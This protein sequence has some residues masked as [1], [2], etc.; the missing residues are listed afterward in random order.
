MLVRVLRVI[1]A[2][3]ALV[4]PTGVAVLDASPASASCPVPTGYPVLTGDLHIDGIP[5]SGARLVATG[6][7]FRAG[8]P[9]C[10][11]VASSPVEFAVATATKTGGFTSKITLPGLTLGQHILR[12]VGHARDGSTLILN[13]AFTNGYALPNSGLRI[14]RWVL[15]GVASVGL[16]LLLSTGR[17][18][19]RR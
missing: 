3:L 17:S 16:I 15:F 13:A 12:A 19:A 11:E 6:S 14:G 9:V 10:L 5:A 8:S 1:L 18:R 7:G 4:V 2:V